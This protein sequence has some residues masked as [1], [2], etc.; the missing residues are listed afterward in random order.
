M[1]I[2]VIGTGL[3][4]QP[5]ASRLIQG[6]HTVLAYNRTQS[7]AESLVAG[8]AR[9]CSRPADL[10]EEADAVVTMLSDADTTA[11]L[12]GIDEADGPSFARTT[13]IQMAT[14][15]PSESKQ[16]MSAVARRGGDYFESPV[17][18]S[19]PEAKS[20]NLILMVG[21]TEEQFVKWRDIL[22]LFGPTP[23][24][25]GPVGAGACVK[26]AMNQLIAAL[27]IAFSESLALVQKEQVDVDAFMAI[28]RASALYAPTY[29]KKLARM[30]ER[31]FANPNFPTK[32]L[33]KDVRLFAK[34]AAEAGISTDTL[35]AFE[36]LLDQAAQQGFAGADYAAVY[37]SVNPPTE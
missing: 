22:A 10:I 29:D 28:T 30:L 27:T 7:K 21:A 9:L 14:I 20:G 5:M 19:L 26:L 1:K 13:V 4:G 17:L 2:G 24:L 12:L 18:G 34:A 36:R 35:H 37:S 8:G 11:R 31:D 25:I 6:G 15:A 32:H 3:M 16:L 33:L 23:R